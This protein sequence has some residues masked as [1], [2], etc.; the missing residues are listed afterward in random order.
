MIIKKPRWNVEALARIRANALR[1]NDFYLYPNSVYILSGPSGQGKTSFAFRIAVEFLKQED[2]AVY[3]ISTGDMSDERITIYLASVIKA[4]DG[5]DY[6]EAA[7]ALIDKKTPLPDRPENFYIVHLNPKEIGEFLDKTIQKH[8]R[9]LVILD[10]LQMLGDWRV[11]SS[12]IAS[13]RRKL[14]EEIGL[15]KFH[16]PDEKIGDYTY[17]IFISQ[18]KKRDTSSRK[19]IRDNLFAMLDDMAG[20]TDLIRQADYIFASINETSVDVPTL[21]ILKTLKTRLPDAT[22]GKYLDFFLNDISEDI[23][24]AIKEFMGGS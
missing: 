17:T 4:L 8:R 1:I 12:M 18:T 11:Q 7:M 6:R 14:T 16:E 3:Y 20:S 2:S 5:S 24:R 9:I 13:Y 22:Q 15:D 19:S 21:P 23:K 10:Y